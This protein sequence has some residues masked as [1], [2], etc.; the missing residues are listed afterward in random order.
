MAVS[1]GGFID[2]D[3]GGMTGFLNV[4]FVLDGSQ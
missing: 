3:G 4:S 1:D 2:D